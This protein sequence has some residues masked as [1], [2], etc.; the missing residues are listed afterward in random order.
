MQPAFFLGTQQDFG[1]RVMPYSNS[2]YFLIVI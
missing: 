2:D 1:N